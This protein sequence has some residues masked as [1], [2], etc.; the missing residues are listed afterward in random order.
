MPPGARRRAQRHRLRPP[1]ILEPRGRFDLQHRAHAPRELRDLAPAVDPAFI[2]EDL[3]ELLPGLLLQPG[4][5]RL[6]G[7]HAVD[8]VALALNLDAR[9]RR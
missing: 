3:A 6:V 4:D 2:R 9:R 1:A 5:E 7:N 8:L